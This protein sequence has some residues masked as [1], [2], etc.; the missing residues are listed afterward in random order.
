MAIER[1]YGQLKRRFPL[2]DYGLRL[3]N[4]M[5]DNANLITAAVTI[6][7][8]CKMHSD[9]EFEETIGQPDETDA[10]TNYGIEFNGLNGKEK[11]YRIMRLFT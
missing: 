7:N 3:Y 6:F 9:P 11:R 1:C 8:F 10:A 2:L 4:D 5:A